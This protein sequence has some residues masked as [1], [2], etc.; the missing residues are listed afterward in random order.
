MRSPI[1]K[2][3]SLRR[4]RNTRQLYP[5]LSQKGE[6]ML[7][8]AELVAFVPTC[9]PQRARRFYE[10]TLGLEFVGEDPFTVVFRANGVMVRIANV[11]G[12]EGFRLPP[13]GM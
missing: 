5:A 2:A 12:V 10:E 7:G 1:L 9:D 3:P 6:D 4:I 11:S 13:P 8:N